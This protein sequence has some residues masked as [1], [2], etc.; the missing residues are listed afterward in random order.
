VRPA[1]IALVAFLLSAGV[2]APADPARAA[3][4]EGDALV[5]LDGGT[6]WKP[7]VHALERAGGR[8][9]VGFPP[10]AFFVRGDDDLLA[11]LDHARV[12][13]GE[14]SSGDTDG[15]SET[16]LL[17][18]LTWNRRL[19]D[20]SLGAPTPIARLSEPDALEP[21]HSAAKGPGERAASGA[22]SGA[23]FY[24]TSEFL[25]G[26]VAVGIILPESDGSIDVNRESW[27]TTEIGEVVAGIEGALAFHAALDARAGLSFYV[28]VHDSMLTGY[29]PIRHGTYTNGEQALWI[30]DCMDSL[31]FTTGDIFYRTRAFDNALRDS[32]DTDWAVTV[33]VIDSS[34]DMD[35]RFDDGTYAYAYV[36]GPF[37]V[38]TYDNWT[39]GI[40]NMNAVAAHE[41]LHPFYAL[42]E[43]SGTSCTEAC[44]YLGVQNQNSA[45][46]CALDVLCLFRSEL[47]DA[48]AADSVCWYT[49]GQ[50]GWRDAD[51]DSILDI[52]D[53]E[54]ATALDPSPDS[55]DSHT[56]TFT[57][58]ASTTALTNLNP[59]GQGNEITTAT[60]ALVEYRVDGGTW[61]P[62]SPS[63][64]VWDEAVEAFVLTTDTLAEASHTIEA[65]AVSNVGN[66][67]ATPAGDTFLV[68]D[69]TPPEPPTLFVASARDTT[70]RLAWTA[71]LTADCQ[72]IRVR[73]RT[74][75]YPS[76]PEDGILIGD[77][78]ALPG[79]ADS[80]LH[81]GVTP[82][83]AY[84]YAAF[85][86]DEVP[87]LSSAATAL[88]SPLDPA[89][90]S[91]LDPAPG[92]L[93]AP[94][95][96]VFRWAPSV[97]EAG[98]SI[99]AYWMTIARDAS[100]SIPLVDSEVVIGSPADTSWALPAVLD[101]GATYFVRLRAKD[102]SS[103]TYG[104]FSDA[105]PFTTRLPVDS[106]FWRPESVSSWTNF[107]SAETLAAGAD[108]RVEVGLVPADTLGVGGHAASVVFTRDAG[109][110]WDTLAL[111]WHHA[112]GD[113]DF[114]RGTL[115][116]GTH[117]QHHE[118]VAFRVE[119]WDPPAA[120]APVVDDA[121]YSF[122][123]GAN[124]VG[125][126]HVPTYVGFDSMSM[127]DPLTGSYVPTE[128]AFQVAA[129][130]GRLEG[131]SLRLRS[132]SDT[133]FVSHAA[134][135][136][137]SLG[138]NDFFRVTLDTVFVTEDSLV[139][140]FVTWGSALLDTTY[141]GGTNDTSLAFLSA[142]SAEA[143]PF[144]F[145]VGTVTGIDPTGPPGAR[146]T[147][148]LQNLPNP[149]RPRT[150][151][152]FDL[153]AAVAGRV[154][155]VVYDA[156][157]RVV[158]RLLDAPMPPGRHEVVWDGT[159]DSGARAA[160]GLYVYELRVGSR[161]EHRRMTLLR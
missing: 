85:A 153:A 82:D 136:I 91:L 36:G 84:Y 7:W 24:D 105:F 75:A 19:A 111:A 117:V 43:Y 148:L 76:G 128:Y 93:H 139:Y 133:V 151:I 124:L 33:F 68:R 147:A 17:A 18:A 87:N 94:F 150:V 114:F 107:A 97:P 69:Q 6:A 156:S 86:L 2:A 96:P 104:F 130:A 47:A 48:F 113:T 67:D 101:R 16:A 108:A 115:L 53:T 146:E 155:L 57:G 77:F 44:G 73:Y 88:G 4:A 116:L 120:G 55:T 92:S 129:P 126:F 141:I 37:A 122:V 161:R 70:V 34:K 140:Y 56:P 27:T 110:S 64:G 26:S 79:A 119:A 38:M 40:E 135:P 118:T 23:G 29:E 106:V 99:V 62:A 51:A 21:P 127:R 22:P 25:I 149:F 10:D 152:P 31:G 8:V 102:A 50:L 15:L 52:L 138:G 100:F 12:H 20:P 121:G 132:A 71:P 3:G 63:D 154:E 39:W 61:S 145:R 66:V 90:P 1:L 42:D 103:E 125:S 32:L 11:D 160:S 137:G 134:A 143:S 159:T 28:V 89:P 112:D 81:S 5:L 65:R 109:A 158:R 9:L 41:I 49:R 74:D 35:G 45:A 60:I 157:G 123:A 78:A 46:A 80:T 83:S 13:R 142:E 59:R 95:S 131:A 58:T 54:P 144:G 30:T 72:G 98:D 14:L